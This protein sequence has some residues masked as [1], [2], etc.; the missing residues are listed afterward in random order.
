[1]MDVVSP[2][3]I[4]KTLTPSSAFLFN[5]SP[6]VIDALASSSVVRR[7]VQSASLKERKKKNQFWKC[8]Y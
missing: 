7:R 8:R 4:S 6:K 2:Q 3:I 1:M 5:S